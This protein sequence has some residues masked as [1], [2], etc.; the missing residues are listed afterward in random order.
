[1]AAPTPALIQGAQK[2]KIDVGG[3]VLEI[4]PLGS[5]NEV[6]RSC[7]VMKFKGKNIMFDCGVHP[8]LTGLAQLPYFDMLAETGT[9]IDYC[10]ITH[11]HMD[12]SG[13]LPYF[14]TR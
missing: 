13:A 12:H 8:G 3:D 4:I 5:G 6:G 14:V 2:R 10:F 9:Q 1:M 11:F 7:C